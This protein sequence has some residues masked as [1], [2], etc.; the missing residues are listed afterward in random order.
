MAAFAGSVRAAAA[1]ASSAASSAANSPR[2]L[3]WF[4]CRS[5]AIGIGSGLP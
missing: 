3:D 2:A 1:A 4:I 5:M